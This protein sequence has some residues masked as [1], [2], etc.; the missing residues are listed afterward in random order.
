M[1]RGNDVEAGKMTE[2]MPVAKIT[3]VMLLEKS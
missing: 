3:L 2:L 1:I